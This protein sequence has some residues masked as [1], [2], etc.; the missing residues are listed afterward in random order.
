MLVTFESD[1]RTQYFTVHLEFS[2]QPISDAL[3]F[4]S[5]FRTQYFTVHLEFSIQ[6]ISNAGYF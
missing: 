2:I 3:S 4:E 6:P 5:D 1:F